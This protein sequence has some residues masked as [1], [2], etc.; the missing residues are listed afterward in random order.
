MN[1]AVKYG[2]R[3]LLLVALQA[4]VLNQLELGFGIQ[5]MVYPLLIVLLPFEI[6]TISL[7]VIAFLMGIL[8]D[9]FSNT[10]GLHAS[11]AVVIAYFRP[12]IFNTFAPRDGYDPLKE[13]NS[14]DMGFRWFLSTFGLMLL[15]HHFWFFLLEIFRFDELLFVLQKTLLSL[16]LSFLLCLIIQ[17]MIVSK[18]KER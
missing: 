12:L 13:G 16:P 8:I 5:F 4:L 9:A 2:V 14:Y 11:S 6:G 15:I 10:Y 18:P 17:A 3:F 7:M 1:V